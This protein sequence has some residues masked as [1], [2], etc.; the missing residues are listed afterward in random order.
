[1]FSLAGIPPLA[2]F[3]GKFSL[4]SSA[5]TTAQ[6]SENTKISSWLI[7][8]AVVGG[9]NAAIAASYYL[10]IVATMYFY[11]ARDEVAVKANQP[12]ALGIGICAV[13]VLA[14]GCFPRI[15]TES[16]RRAGQGYLAELSSP[17]T[18]NPRREA[19]RVYGQPD[20]STQAAA[21]QPVAVVERRVAD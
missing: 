16:A 10:R 19:R 8:L 5:I 14:I 1:M 7:M 9:I 13:L 18:A 11:R 6:A 20:S 15:V 21:V 17:E 4:F 2:G 12:V 3:W